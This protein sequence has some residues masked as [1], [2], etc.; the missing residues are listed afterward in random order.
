MFCLSICKLRFPAPRHLNRVIRLSQADISSKVKARFP[1]LFHRLVP[2]FRVL[3]LFAG[4]HSHFPA[5]VH[6][7]S[8]LFRILITCMIRCRPD[9]P[10]MF[11][12]LI[13]VN[14]IFLLLPRPLRAILVRIPRVPL[15]PKRPIPSSWFNPLLLLPVPVDTLKKSLKRKT[16][17]TSTF[18]G[19]RLF[20]FE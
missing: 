9:V 13:L 15:I 8:S 6:Q 10:L 20:V 19:S 4:L 16:V 18:V 7:I 5:L 1:I 17:L 14:S 11:P 3:P 12:L 2:R